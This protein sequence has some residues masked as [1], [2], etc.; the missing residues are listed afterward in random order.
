MCAGLLKLLA[1]GVN[2]WEY[3]RAVKYRW[4]QRTSSIPVSIAGPA[5][6]WRAMHW[7][8]QNAKV[9]PSASSASKTLLSWQPCTFLIW[10]V[11]TAANQQKLASSSWC[12]PS[13]FSF[14]PIWKVC[15]VCWHVAKSCVNLYSWM[16]TCA[17]VWNNVCVS[18][19]FIQ[20][21]HVFGVE[22]R[23]V[24]QHSWPRWQET[25]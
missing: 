17:G 6:R 10:V 15:V 1:H 21:L 3:L 11:S 12:S 20:C 9:M 4:Q 16:C 23:L 7:E 18:T 5:E 8:V 24:Y 19:V 22:H 2:V 14:L 13:W 25:Q